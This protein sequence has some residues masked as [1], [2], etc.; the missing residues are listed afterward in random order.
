VAVSDL[1]SGATASSRPAVSASL[2]VVLCLAL[3]W[4]EPFAPGPSTNVVPWLSAAAL[5]LAALLFCAPALPPRRLLLAAGAVVVFVLAHP[6]EGTLDRAG[7]AG[8]VAL[9]LA[10]FAIGRGRTRAGQGTAELIALA[11]MAAALLSSGMALLQ[12]F[13]ATGAL[14]PWVHGAGAGEAVA[15]LRQ[16]N[17]FATLTA[18]GFAAVLWLAG[19][20]R[21][22]MAIAAI[23]VTVLAAA[24]AATS[25]RTGLLEWVLLLGL[26]L[27]WRGGRRPVVLGAFGLAV[28]AVAA[29]ALPALLAAVVGTPADSVFHRL[30]A[31]LG[32]SSRRVLWAN[33]LELVAQRPWF[34]WGWGELDYAHYAHIYTGGARFCDI[35][36]NAHNLPLHVAVELG[37]PAALL[38][39]AATLLAL[40]RGR[41]WREVVADRQLAWS[42]LAVIGVHS[43]VEYPLWYAPFQVA[44]GLALGLLAAP[45][46]GSS[47]APLSNALG[48]GLVAAG[49]ALLAYAG[50]DYARIG[51]I[52]VTPDA[53][54]APWRD[55]ALGHAR[56]SWLFASQAS[57]AEL[58]LTPLSAE[59]LPWTDATAQALL[60]Y[61]PE[62]RII[63]KAIESATLA[64]RLDDAVVQLA[65]YRAAFPAEYAKWQAAQKRRLE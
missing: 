20:G 26:A 32:C 9:G 50:W 47:V 7:F 55:D 31:D 41:F 10:G 54:L 27:L 16:R 43:L 40:W 3:P 53:R 35:L 1:A 48:G 24:D 25:S 29:A 18:I 4:V 13:D 39:C 15:N 6:A 8:A 12:Y 45:R 51:Q 19:R 2:L 49:L 34:G 44:L 58:T 57:F 14:H 42:V 59:N 64:G 28:Y 56:K 30:G 11:W 62:P 52:Y 36:D 37:L 63:E 46:A 65:R 33:V 60:H 61:S 38:L 21:L 22:S 17:Q 5:T 23:A